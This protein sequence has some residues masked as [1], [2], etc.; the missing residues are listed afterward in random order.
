MTLYHYTTAAGLQ[1]IIA[2]KSLWTSNY[3]FLNDT[4]E[5]RYGWKIVVDA[6]DRREAEIKDRSSFAWQTYELF[7]RN[8][9]KAYVFVGSLTSQG[10]LLSQWR[11]YNRGQGFAIGFNE[12]WLEQNAVVQKFDISRVL[13][14][15]DEQRAA[16]DTTVDLLIQQL[17]EPT[18]VLERINTWQVQA[19]KT[20]LRLKDRHF[21]EEKEFRLVWAGHSWPVRLKTR[22]S[23]TGLIPYQAF[24]FDLATTKSALPHPNNFGVEEIIVGPALGQQQVIAV[25]ALLAS[26][27]MRLAIRRSSIPYVAD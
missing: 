25:E 1:G 24:Q 2:S 21:S 11:G 8:R 4:S 14:D 6:F 22:I 13:Y 9:D 17:V 10:D 5:F 23:S 3:Q 26:Q 19:V 27:S 18:T 16:A 15:A 7:M 12:D 20:A